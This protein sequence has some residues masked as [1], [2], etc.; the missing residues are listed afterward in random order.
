MKNF[1]YIYRNY[2]SFAVFTFFIFLFGVFSFGRPFSW[3][4][5]DTKPIS[6]FITEF[7]IL[8]C[9]PLLF[10][11]YKKLIKIP[12]LVKISFMLFISLGS[13]YLIKGIMGSN[14]FALR[15]GVLCWYLL[16]APISYLIFS[17]KNKLKLL[18]A[19]L[20]VSN[21]IN[22][23]IG[24]LLLLNYYPDTGI[25]FLKAAPKSFNLGLYYG[26]AI[27]F[28]FAFF[29]NIKQKIKFLAVL[30]IAI[31]VYMLVFFSKRTLWVA[32]LFLL[33]Y[34]IIAQRMLFIKF[35]FKIAPIVILIC[36][37]LFYFDFAGQNKISKTSY[38]MSRVDSMKSLILKSIFPSKQ[39]YE[40]QSLPAQVYK[41]ITPGEE[42]QIW[43]NITW[44]FAIWSQSLKFGLES[45]VLGRG[46]G[47]YPRYIIYGNPLPLPQKIDTDSGVTP[48]HNH[49]ITVFFKM[50]LI[51]LSLFIFLN[52][53]VFLYGVAYICKM[54]AGFSKSFVTALLG[55]F[56]FWHSIA[57]FFD[58]IDSPPTSLFLW[59][60]I[61]LIFV[62][63]EIDN[64][65]LNK[66]KRKYNV[67]R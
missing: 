14:L 62:A 60:I 7:I 21:L 41:S 13:W 37:S 6:F 24:R 17:S 51:G 10:F 5:F 50:G 23:F 66:K 31:N 11:D 42:S 35:L 36:F 65:E 3:L 26:I 9:F 64:V 38:L 57:F 54:A 67:L 47:V 55:A 53:Y 63:I 39:I 46:F 27:A 52:L 1:K 28:L 2:R 16:F 48:A 49:I 12:L 40:R 59:V 45:F 32:L 18:L 25:W 15:D 29:P 20:F 22:L 61:G 56:I 43:S 4:H 8:L 34:F 30:L 19:V 58:A 44:R 33:L